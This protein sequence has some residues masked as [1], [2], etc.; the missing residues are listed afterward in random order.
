MSE[1]IA[2]LAF[3]PCFILSQAFCAWPRGYAVAVSTS[4]ASNPRVP[5]ANICET[6]RVKKYLPAT[7]AP[8]AC[9]AST[10]ATFSSSERHLA[11]TRPPSVLRDKQ[12]R[13][14]RD[15]LRFLPI[16]HRRPVSSP[17]NAEGGE[18]CSTAG[19]CATCPFMK[20]NDLDALM[21]VVANADQ[22]GT[23]SGTFLPTL[24]RFCRRPTLLLTREI[25]G[26]ECSR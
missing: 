16:C 20:M 1:P 23:V 15:V 21:D 13:V 18:G 5:I 24:R 26:S 17:H 3:P 8:T 2:A 10:C 9:C 7:L 19:G 14:V 6:P 22:S 12:R 25:R 4:R 11:S